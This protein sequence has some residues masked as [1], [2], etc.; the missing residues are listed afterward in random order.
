M[1]TL[2][3]YRRDILALTDE[4]LEEFVRAW[5]IAK[6]EYHEVV[7]YSGSGDRGRDVVGYLSKERAEG[8]WHNYQCKHYG[9]TLPT[10]TALRE[11]AKVL[12]Y[13][14]VGE[15]TA[16]KKFNFVAPRG[17]NRD[18]KTLI[19]KPTELRDAIL[20]GWD[21]DIAASIIENQ[22]VSLSDALRSFISSWDFSEVH[23]VTVD[24]ILDHQSSNAVLHK[25]FDADPGPAPAGVTPAEVQV[26]EL[27]Y[28]SQ[29]LHGYG[30]RAGCDF[31]DH[32]AVKEHDEHWQDLGRQ[33][34][35]FFDAD[36]F[37][38]FFRDNTNVDET[39]R[40]ERDVLNGVVDTCNATQGDTLQRVE[41]T[42]TQAA[43][44]K[45]GGVLGRHAGITVKQGMCHHFVN[46]GALKWR[47]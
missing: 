40:F 3:R 20:N 32:H 45:P 22:K 42:M 10:K 19:F 14:H 29:L 15:F 47:K 33:R 28:V 12:Y 6:K 4:Q 17:L 41:A 34:E 21:A 26:V 9:R 11:I 2:P 18:L 35:R 30:E 43:N 46:D 37:T 23:E 36:A 25:W 31:A 16:P 24:H 39:T 44:L 13:A 8:D 38:R 7:L 5:V 27:P 1:V